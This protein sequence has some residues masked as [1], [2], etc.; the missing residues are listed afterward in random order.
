MS[1]GPTEIILVL[2]IAL[3]VFGPSKLPQMGR[4]L[5]RGISE[6]KRAADTAKEE[7][8][9]GEV[10][11]EVREVKD[12]V[13]SSLG[14]DELKES[15]TG[16]TSTVD[17]TKKSVTSVVDDVAKSVGAD[18]LT[19][20]LGSVKAAMAFNPRKAAIGLVTS[21]PSSDA[22]LQSS[23]AATTDESDA[24]ARALASPAAVTSGPADGG[25][26]GPAAD[27]QDELEG[28]LQP[29]PVEA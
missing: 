3:L 6:F 14:L 9:L 17:D 5:G 18:K 10:L 23:E 25:S 2:T 24:G 20:G 7:L 12:D 1:I 28:S 4:T 27:A 16:V 29:V 11:D 21:R 22:G 26:P 8:G 13:T 19:A 15:V